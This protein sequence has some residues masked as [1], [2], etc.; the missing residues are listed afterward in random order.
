MYQKSDCRPL[1]IRFNE[2]VKGLTCLRMLCPNKVVREHK[3]RLLE[4]VVGSQI[5]PAEDFVQ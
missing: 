4:I 5:G 2:C 3:V 1:Q